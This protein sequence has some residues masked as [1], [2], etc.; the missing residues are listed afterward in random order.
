MEVTER[1]GGKEESREEGREEKKEGQILILK[2]MWWRVSQGSHIL[3]E[4][5]AAE[6]ELEA[7]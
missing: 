7:P 4:R 2:V 6:A 3:P 5:L 1:E